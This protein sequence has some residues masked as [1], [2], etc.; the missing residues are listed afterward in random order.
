M[1]AEL[2]KIVVVFLTDFMASL[3]NLINYRAI[4]A[5]FD[6]D[7]WFLFAVQVKS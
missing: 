1:L 4:R 3:A 5:H 2:S 6:Y 7:M